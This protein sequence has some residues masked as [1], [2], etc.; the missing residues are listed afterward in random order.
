MGQGSSSTHDDVD[1]A[2]AL[3]QANT[4]DELQLLEG[5]EDIVRFACVVN[6]NMC[7]D[8]LVFAWRGSLP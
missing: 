8:A 6:H 5:H 4:I 2:F 3:E 1:E 7:V